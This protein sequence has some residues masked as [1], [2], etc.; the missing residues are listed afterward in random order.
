MRTWMRRGTGL[1]LMT[2]LALLGSQ[3]WSPST[4]A[5]TAARQVGT[6]E[7][8]DMRVSK[9]GPGLEAHI[10]RHHPLA[11]KGAAAAPERGVAAQSLAGGGDDL[12][13]LASPELGA[14]EAVTIRAGRVTLAATVVDQS[15]TEVVKQFLARHA[16]LYGLTPEQVNER[17]V[18][19]FRRPSYSM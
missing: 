4:Q 3:V 15:R 7:N 5:Q 11:A 6:L 13:V 9:G 1:R 17:K 19:Q 14:P 8:F 18:G 12:E 16:G 10:E 2:G